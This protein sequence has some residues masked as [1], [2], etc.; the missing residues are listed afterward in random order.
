MGHANQFNDAL[1]LLRNADPVALARTI[2]TT[3]EL[4]SA[5]DAG[6]KTLLIHACELATGNVAIP[7]VQGNEQQ[8]ACIDVLLEHGADPSAA[9]ND[10]WAPLHVAA[11]SG[12][13]P[14][15]RRLIAVGARREG[16]L[17][18]TKGGSPLSLA[19]FYAKREMGELL[20]A[21]AVPDNLRNAAALG[22]PLERFI[23]GARL[24]SEAVD[25]TDF[26]R[27]LLLFPPWQRSYTRQEVIDEALT[28]A[29][30]NDRLDSMARLVSLG[31]NVNSNPYRGTALLWAVYADRA[32]AATW[33]LDHGADP[34]LRHDF[35]GSEHGR[36]A[37]VALHLAA[38][39]NCLGCV[40]L[41]LERGADTTIRDAAYDA[42]PLG[43]AEH[44]GAQ[45]AAELLR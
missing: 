36:A 41:L 11:M 42:T 5:R 31:A 8:H 3:P 40:R 33:L 38:Q 32:S 20:A 6:G 35:G 17:L 28:W 13:L 10:G 29:A 15:A 23:D 25:G 18:G 37:V 26:Y 12:N 45:Q 19:L 16:S 2:E 39:Y 30:R 44:A 14:L 43:W 34:N 9:A 22:R 7:A 27:P 24:T 21:P 4:T 1:E